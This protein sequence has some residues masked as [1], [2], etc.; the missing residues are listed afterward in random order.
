MPLDPKTLRAALLIA[1]VIVL[2]AG[3]MSKGTATETSEGLVFG[4]KPVVLWSRLIAIPLYVAI[5]LY[6]ALVQHRQVPI[7]VPILLV[8]LVGYAL[9]QLPGTIVLT[10]TAVI[11]RF[12]LRADKTIHY[13]EVMTIQS[14]QAGRI[15]RVLG[16]NR[17]TI[18]HNSAHADAPRFRTE[19]EARTNK[20][21]SS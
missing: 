11:Q 20:K 10:R 2:Y 9:Y 6:P 8:A 18:T 12:W 15:T 5:F 16:D 13:P 1:V 21:A 14:L 17:T 4:M 19:L 3:R 7:W